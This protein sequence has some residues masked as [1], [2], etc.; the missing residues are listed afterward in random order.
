MIRIFNKVIG[1]GGI[2]TGEIYRLEGNHTLG[3]EESRS[4]HLLGTKDFC[5]LHIIL[6]YIAVLTRNLKPEIE[7]IPVSAIGDDSRGGYILDELVKAGMNVKY[8]KKFTDTPTLHSICF[9]YTDQTGGNI[10]ESKSACSKV[11]SDMLRKAKRIIDK[12]TIVLAVPE[13]PLKSRIDFIKLGAQ[14]K[15][16]IAASFTSL[17]M[18]ELKPSGILGLIDL[19][20]VNMDEAC[21]LS[22]M[23]K[24]NK[25]SDIVSAC[26][27]NLM[28]LNP[29]IKLTV[30]N[31]AEGVFAYE[32]GKLEYH[33]AFQVN[34]VNT[35]GAGDAFMAGLLIGIIKGQTIVGD[36]E[37]S[38]LKY[39][40]ALAGMS[41]T[42][43]DTI[44]FG[45][46]KKTLEEFMLTNNID[47]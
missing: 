36:Q 30:T 28:K 35:A 24:V 17:E 20:S 38:C 32:N 15:A 45:I 46:S 13:I 19:L 9:Q 25:P 7:V 23:A 27:S 22:G 11:N 4:G 33:K 44:H 31:G 16:F 37:N 3:R 1:T 21:M 41:V 43:R 39:A 14:Q 2:G 47:S 6:H 42:S 40:V 10:T 5:K 18:K 29:N 8:I 26:I 12:N 34:P